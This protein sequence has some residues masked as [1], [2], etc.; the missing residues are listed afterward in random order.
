LA[1]LEIIQEDVKYSSIKIDLAN[2]KQI[3]YWTKA[4]IKDWFQV[5]RGKIFRVDESHLF[6]VFQTTVYE[7]KI[8][9]YAFKGK[10]VLMK[11]TGGK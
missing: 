6:T 4:K 8:P 9:I 1:G 10:A 5:I 3:N 2:N 11:V 7:D